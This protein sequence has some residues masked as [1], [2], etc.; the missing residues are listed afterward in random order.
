M[1]SGD[2]SGMVCG[3]LF[4]AFVLLQTKVVTTTMKPSS[5]ALQAKKCTHYERII[6]GL[7]AM[8]PRYYRGLIPQRWP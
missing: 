1:V 4:M 5:Q 8:A 2:V 7:A 3:A 6:I